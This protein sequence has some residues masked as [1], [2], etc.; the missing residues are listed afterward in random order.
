MCLSWKN[1]HLKNLF[2]DII[3]AITVDGSLSNGT[4]VGNDFAT[5]RK[6]ARKFILDTI[7]F[8]LNEYHVDGFRFDLM[9]A[10][11]IETM[12]KIHERCKEEAVPIMLLGEGWDLPTALSFRKESYFH[13]TPIN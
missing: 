8:W 2:P 6:M 5:E 7:D 13:R 12:K 3:S 1:H 10:M 9:G 11:D 4:G